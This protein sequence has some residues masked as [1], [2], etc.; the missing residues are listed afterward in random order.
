[1]PYAVASYDG[2]VRDIILA[3]KEQA[4]FGLAS[5]LAGAIEAATL[6][7]LVDAEWD[8]RPFLL[9]PAPTTRRAIR[10]RGHSPVEALARVAARRLR[11]D[12]DCRPVAALAIRNPTADQAGLDA[13]ARAAN[14]T[15]AYGVRR[16]YRFRLQAWP[17]VVVDDIITTGATAGEAARALRTVG[18]GVLGVAVVAATARRTSRRLPPIE[19]GH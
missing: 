16:R 7:A 9:V 11:R 19:A 5:A 8:G 15:G 6:A 2:A 13:L 17:V 3:Y 14:L 4:G 1:M 10:D 18:A 12:V